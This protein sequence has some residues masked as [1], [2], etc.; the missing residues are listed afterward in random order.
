MST[1]LLTVIVPTIGRLSLA[2]TL[3]S[4]RSQAPAEAL[5]ILVV[6]DTHGSLFAGPLAAVPVLAGD[7]DAHYFSHDGGLHCVG[8]PQRQAGMTQ[9]RG[10]W[11]AFSQDDN[12]W[13]PGAWT[14]LFDTLN[15]T[16]DHHPYLFRVN[17][18]QAGVVW[19]R[20]FLALGNADADG[21]VVPNDPSRLG[22]WELHY[23][24][25]YD[26][27][28]ATVTAYGGALTYAEPVLVA[29]RPGEGR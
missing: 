5:E 15:D 3:R 11:L 7:Y 21:M 29:Y 18:R 4:I 2:A 27:L 9:A 8:H 22:T 17:T 28:A 26:F 10:A 23:A 14:A 25:D 20:P 13:L 6:G 24:G 19:A 1:P 12:V 16:H